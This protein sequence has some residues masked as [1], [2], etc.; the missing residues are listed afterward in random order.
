MIKRKLI[1]VIVTVVIV[2]AS[3]TTLLFY[4]GYF[5]PQPSL[6]AKITAFIAEGPSPI[7]GMEMII[8][9]NV[10]VENT[11]TAEIKNGNLTIERMVNGNIS[12][13]GAYDYRPES[14]TLH[15]GETLQD[16][17]N[18]LIGFDDSMKSN[19]SFTAVLRGDGAVLDERK[20]GS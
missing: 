5:S 8:T 15:A 2:F 4:S 16:Q 7:V 17:I 13:T 12:E 3:V 19:Q 11:G 18:L 14:F 9:F 10:T 20:L 1:L 6:Q